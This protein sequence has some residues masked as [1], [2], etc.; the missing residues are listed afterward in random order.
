MRTSNDAF[1]VHVGMLIRRHRRRKRLAQAALARKI[2]SAPNTISQWENGH[3]DMT[4]RGIVG[5]ARALGVP[6]CSLVPPVEG[7][8]RCNCHCSGVINTDGG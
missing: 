3:R 2:G 7:M 5:I 6:V 4:F 8:V 1:L